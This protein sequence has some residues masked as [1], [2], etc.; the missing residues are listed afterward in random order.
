MLL[1]LVLHYG[2]DRAVSLLMFRKYKQVDFERILLSWRKLVLRWGGRKKKDVNSVL[3]GLLTQRILR[4]LG[5]YGYEI[6]CPSLD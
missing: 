1:V 3:G 4:T 6:C 2:P 5:I